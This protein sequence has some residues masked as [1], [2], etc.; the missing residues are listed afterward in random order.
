MVRVGGPGDP[1]ALRDDVPRRHELRLARP[2]RTPERTARR[3]EP[4]GGAGGD[5]GRPSAQLRRRGSLTGGGLPADFGR[6]TCRVQGDV[7]DLRA[8]AVRVPSREARWDRAGPDRGTSRILGRYQC[9]A[10]GGGPTFRHRRYRNMSR[11]PSPPPQSHRY[12]AFLLQPRA[13]STE[14][15]TSRKLSKSKSALLSGFLSRHRARRAGSAATSGGGKGGGSFN[16]KSDGLMSARSRTSM[17]SAGHVKSSENFSLA[18]VWA[19]PA[20][21]GTAKSASTTE[22]GSTAAKNALREAGSF[23]HRSLPRSGSQW[24]GQE[25]ESTRPR[26]PRRV[27]GRACRLV[28][29][30]ETERTLG[31]DEEA[32]SRPGGIRDADRGERPGPHAEVDRSG[33]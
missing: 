29:S 25:V 9:V 14:L 11:C 5:R 19:L 30:V 32:Y 27:R 2:D 23:T 26:G 22:G 6:K 8:D 21:T 3:A 10:P 13:S 7:L 1:E 28:I 16:L 24:K 4:G 17:L 12:I 15:S 20:S 18:A 33:V 31:A